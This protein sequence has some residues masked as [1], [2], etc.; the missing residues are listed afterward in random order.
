M[1][2]STNNV[3]DQVDTFAT[4]KYKPVVKKVHAILA[5]L[6]EKYRIT[7]NIVSDPLANLLTLNP[8]FPDFKPTGRYT[9]EGHDVI[10]KCERR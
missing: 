10:N 3:A 2:D 8:K 9:A 1:T 4:C 6:P 5:K 7:H